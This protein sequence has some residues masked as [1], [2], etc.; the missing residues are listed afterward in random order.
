MSYDESAAVM[1][2]NRKQ[3]ENLAYRARQALKK[4]LEKEAKR[5]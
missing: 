3:I 4:E 5:P 1:K 2:K